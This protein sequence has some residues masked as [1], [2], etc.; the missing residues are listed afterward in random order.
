MTGNAPHPYG[1]T[2]AYLESQI[3][4]NPEEYF[5]TVHSWVGFALDDPQHERQ[6]DWEQYYPIE[7]GVDGKPIPKHKWKDVSE[8]EKSHYEL[9]KVSHGE[10]VFTQRIIDNT[11]EEKPLYVSIRI[12]TLVRMG[13]F[14][15]IKQDEGEE[16]LTQ[17][18]I[19]PKWTRDWYEKRVGDGPHT[20][21]DQSFARDCIKAMWFIGE[22][23][24][25]LYSMR[26]MHNSVL[27][28]KFES[29]S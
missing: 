22:E 14:R 8:E 15:L 7:E 18:I 17:R 5:D 29:S 3:S 4:G 27:K 26:D 28:T 6:Y 11:D 19:V 24:E 2:L 25:L 1:P 23:W 21:L 12:A 20:E 13:V 9:L 16:E 10:S